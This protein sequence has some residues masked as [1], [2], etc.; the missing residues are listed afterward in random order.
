[1]PIPYEKWGPKQC[2]E[3]FERLKELGPQNCELQ[4]RHYGEA[5]LEG[6]GNG[7]LRVV[8]LGVTA[9]EQPD[10]NESEWCPPLC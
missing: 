10:V 8:P 2:V 7:H 6:K 5:T 3:L 9:T 1:M 4:L